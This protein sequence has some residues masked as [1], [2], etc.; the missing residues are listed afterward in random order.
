MRLADI[1]T[2]HP[3]LR[4]ET[5]LQQDVDTWGIHPA[6][7]AGPL[8]VALPPGRW[9]AVGE[10][11]IDRLCGVEMSLQLRMLSRHIELSEE[12]GL[13]L[14][15]HCVRGQEQILSLRRQA[16][17][18][19]PWILH[20]FRG[21]PQQLEQLTGQGLYVSFGP[22]FNA[23]SARAC[24][25]ERM[26][27]ETDCHAIHVGQVC[28]RLALARGMEAGELARIVWDNFCRVFAPQGG[29]P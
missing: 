3:S 28:E 10:C 18:T 16:R 9:Q 27:M 19:M 29:C 1:H 26:L 11:G 15:L 8:P 4:G 5:V 20:G 25:P 7:A 12:H 14:I 24:P 13:P 17:P 6:G 21:K 23:G 22:L 2:H